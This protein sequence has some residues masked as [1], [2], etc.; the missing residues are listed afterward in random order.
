MSQRKMAIPTFPPGI[1][2]CAFVLVSVAVESLWELSNK[3]K[4]FF[5]FV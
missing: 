1:H 4:H 2:S 3:E 5:I